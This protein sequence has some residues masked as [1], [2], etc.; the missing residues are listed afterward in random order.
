MKNFTLKT[1]LVLFTSIFVL[2]AI[3][4]SCKKEVN[5][6]KENE[7]V[8][9]ENDET[10]T[11]NIIA[12][13]EKMEYYRDSPGL[14]SGELIPSDTA[15]LELEALLNYH[16]CNTGIYINDAKIKSSQIIMPLDELLRIS[17]SELAE[18]Y[19]D[20]VIDRIQN[21]MSLVNFT[22]RKLVAVD[23]K[24]EE[25]NSSGDAVI[26][27][28][29]FI[30]NIGTLSY[31]TIEYGWWWGQLEGDC[32][33]SPGTDGL[34]DATTILTYELN[35]YVIN[36]PPP[37]GYKWRYVELAIE[38]PLVPTAYPNGNDDIEHDNHQDY[39]IYYATTNYTPHTQAVKCVS[40]DAE[41]G[42]N[43]EMEFYLTNYGV[44][45]S[46]IAADHAGNEVS[47]LVEYFYTYFPPPN[48]EERL[49]H[50]LTI[51]VG[52]KYL[53][54]VGDELTDLDIMLVD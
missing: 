50:D 14:K 29:S 5:D 52:K 27:I 44:I 10:I 40:T 35:K 30:A 28:S 8:F 11:A 54:L 20:E 24:M 25:I 51:I 9:T 43:L 26:T 12:F 15:I 19:Y 46:N 33:H 49:Q 16:Y 4:N 47:Y 39:L 36:D 31:E 18:L 41:I 7:T 32:Q 38:G 13:K 2:V 34:M 42:F 53:V 6:Q 1:M 45:G 23:I 37:P 21:Q 17:A 22:N 48:E 3:V